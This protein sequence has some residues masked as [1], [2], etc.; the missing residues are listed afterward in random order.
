MYLHKDRATFREII[1]EVAAAASQ[2]AAIIE[3]DYYVTMILRLLSRSLDNVVFKGGTSLS[4]GYRAIKRF[5]EDIDIT[6]EA[7]I[8]SAARKSLKRDAMASISRELDMPIQNWDSIKSGLDFNAYHFAYSSVLDAED[9]RLMSHV[10]LETALGSYAFPTVSLQIGSVIGDLLADGG[11]G[12]IAAKYEL[13][14]FTMKVQA[15]ERTFVDKIFALCDYYL[16]GRSRRYSR[17]LYDICMLM[18][19]VSLDESFAKLFAEVRAHRAAMKN[20]PSA[21]DGVDLPSVISELCDSAFYERDYEDITDYFV[22]EPVPYQNAIDQMKL[23]V[24]YLKD[25]GL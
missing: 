17:H 22:E 9:D 6:F 8:G 19:R 15:I 10:I 4:K 20:C 12:E 23:I 2:R 18:Q 25:M 5:S 14:P 11:H 7:P 1:D 3:K 24:S 13:E 16:A 21:K